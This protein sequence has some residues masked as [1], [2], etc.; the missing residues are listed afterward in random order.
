MQQYPYSVLIAGPEFRPGGAIRAVAQRLADRGVGVIPAHGAGLAGS[1][2]A[3]PGIGAAVLG[4]DLFGSEGEFHAV[5][6]EI[7]EL[8]AR[9]PVVLLADT[10]SEQGVPRSAVQRADEFFWLPADSP[11]FVAG[12]V[13]H[14]V[15]DHAQQVMSQFL[16]ELTGDPGP[17]EWDCYLPG[18][19]GALAAAGDASRC[20]AVPPPARGDLVPGGN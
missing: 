1:L 9:P 5:L 16:A 18:P 11:S 14:L 17:G 12:Q 4:W 20:L 3:V 19:G 2:A 13:E 10:P 7:R 6:D 8:P 15:R